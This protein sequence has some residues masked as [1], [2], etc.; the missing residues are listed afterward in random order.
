MKQEF[1][2]KKIWN[3]ELFERIKR[4][5]KYKYREQWDDN[6][7]N[8]YMN[9]LGHTSRCRLWC[10]FR[11]RF[12]C[13][14]WCWFRCWSRCGFQCRWLCFGYNIGWHCI[15]ITLCAHIRYRF[16]NWFAVFVRI[17][18][19]SGTEFRCLSYTFV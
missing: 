5:N 12:W 2:H 13:R 11:F 10:R 8:G 15:P 6:Q 17:H 16:V 7:T 3:N 4:L 19:M 18:V 1:S 14:F 9:T